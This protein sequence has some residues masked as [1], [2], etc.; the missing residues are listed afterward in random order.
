M[1]TPLDDVDWTAVERRARRHQVLVLPAVAVSAAAFMVV[2]GGQVPAL[3]GPLG[4]AVVVALTGAAVVGMLLGRR[5]DQR[6]RAA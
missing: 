2:L 3:L 6:R 1:S 4:G 5:P